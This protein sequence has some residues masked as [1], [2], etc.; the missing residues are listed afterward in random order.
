[1]SPGQRD[2]KL[3]F[4]ARAAPGALGLCVLSGEVATQGCGPLGS[5]CTSAV[6]PEVFGQR[7]GG[8]SES[9]EPSKG[10][11]AG[12]GSA[13]VLKLPFQVTSVTSS[14]KRGGVLL[15]LGFFSCYTSLSTFSEY[16]SSCQV[17]YEG[18]EL[19]RAASE[20]QA[21]S[22]RSES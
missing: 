6:R 11:M 18:R 1:M 10:T 5:S 13:G 9:P 12:E 8:K 22:S 14:L 20:P 2:E 15:L 21:V 7:G 17:R 19:P 16:F 3:P 4:L